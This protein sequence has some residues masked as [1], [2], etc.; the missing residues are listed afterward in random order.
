MAGSDG[1]RSSALLVKRQW[2]RALG[3][4]IS[5][6]FEKVYDAGSRESRRQIKGRNGEL[7]VWVDTYYSL[8]NYPRNRSLTLEQPDGG[9][10]T[11]KLIEDDVPEDSTSGKG[12]IEVGQF[13]GFSPSGVAKGQLVYVNWGRKE[14]F[15]ALD[16]LG[17][18]RPF[19]NSTQARV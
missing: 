6:P 1:D 11:A 14:D 7:R 9:K 13:H 17:E 8:L 12:R 3:L 2:E 5:K 19:A 15:D 18:P 4:P 10:F 16:K